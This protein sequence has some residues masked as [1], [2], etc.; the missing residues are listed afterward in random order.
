VCP[1]VGGEG[2]LQSDVWYCK[3]GSKGRGAGE[4][5]LR[6]KKGKLLGGKKIGPTTTGAESRLILKPN[7]TCG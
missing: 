5:I 3:I 6:S 7:L 4:G 2:G 1:I